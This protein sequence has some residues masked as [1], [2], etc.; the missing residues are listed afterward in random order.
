MR[1]IGLRAGVAKW[2]K[3][4]VFL[5]APGT[6]TPHTITNDT[7]LEAGRVLEAVA[8]A[9]EDPFHVVIDKV[10]QIVQGRWGWHLSAGVNVMVLHVAGVAAAV[11]VHVRTVNWLGCSEDSRRGGF[12]IATRRVGRIL[13]FDRRRC[14]GGGGVSLL[15]RGIILSVVACSVAVLLVRR[16]C[17]LLFDIS[18]YVAVLLAVLLAVVVFLTAHL[19]RNFIVLQFLV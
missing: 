17:L 19:V 16:R 15:I 14:G 10:I 3:C 6:G 13:A 5:R 11:L 8:P 9:N 18:N 12:W 4:F 1:G 7:H 2:G